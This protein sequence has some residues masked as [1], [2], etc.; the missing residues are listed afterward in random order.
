MFS[1]GR[2]SAGTPL[3]K[4]KG[5]FVPSAGYLPPAS[6]E[7]GVLDVDSETLFNGAA[8]FVATLAI[9]IFILGVDPGFSP[10]TKYGLAVVFLAGVF[11]LT[12]RTD[13]QQLLLFG[14]GV[15]IVGF[16]TLFLDVVGTIGLG[17]AV[18]VLGLLVIAAVLFGLRTRF[19]DD[20]HFVTGR[21]ATVGLAVIAILAVAVFAVDV[22]TG[23]PTYELRPESEIT[24][25]AS[26]RGELRVASVVVTNPTPLPEQV[27]VP[28][29][30][31][32]AAGNWSTYRP[33]SDEL[34]HQPPVRAHLGVR[35][36]Y[37]DH[38][39]SLGSE[40]YPITL[41]LDGARLRGESFP[42][43]RTESCPVTATG[44]PYLALYEE[45]DD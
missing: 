7:R 35:G 43:E 4:L 12:Q 8:A 31:V 2:L 15:V 37:G 22:G 19:D 28:N 32:C 40:T 41:H 36:G 1:G 33:G 16:V 45:P 3:G 17:N 39:M 23:G 10:V 30:A 26:D 13:D 42:V 24:V 5:G 6:I 29:Y 14:Y 9:G 21:T 34:D 44:T 20:N 27:D 25:P 18:T 11:A 38:V